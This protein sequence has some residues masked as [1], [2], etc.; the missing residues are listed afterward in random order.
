[1]YI[2]NLDQVDRET[3]GVGLKAANLGFLF[4]S[5][6][7]VPPGFVVTSEA[8]EKFLT[9]TGI[10]ME[11][12][13]I[14]GTVN[15][16]DPQTAFRA[17]GW[18]KEMF[19]KVSGMDFLI[20]EL[21]SAYNELS[22]GKDVSSAG[23]AALDIVRAGRSECFVS[24]RP[25]FSSGKEACFSGHGKTSL[26]LISHR[27]VLSGIKDC[28]LS[29]F[30]P[31]ALIY[32][33]LQGVEGFSLGVIV[34]KMADSELSGTLFTSEPI[35]G[36]RGKA[37]V[38]GFWGLG[39]T[40]SSGNVCPDQFLIDKETGVT[41]KKISRKL[42]LRR[43]GPLSGVTIQEKVPLSRV[44]AETLNER[45]FPKFSLIAK[46]AEE[47][48]EGPQ[49][50]E[51]GVD[52][53]KI[54]LLQARPLVFSKAQGFSNA[55]ATEQSDSLKE[56]TPPSF[57]GLGVSAGTAKGKA[58]AVPDFSALQK[59]ETPAILLAKNL[60][61]EI[62]PYLKWFSG[63]ISEQGGLGSCLASIARESGIPIVTGI[64]NATIIL[65][66]KEIALDGMAGSVHD[67]PHNQKTYQA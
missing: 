5:G 11:L 44:S 41:E 58:L 51:W 47:L 17:C 55:Q 33:K 50:I 65:N 26:N 4:K 23:G 52:R 28:W 3:P 40:L 13:G 25:S 29:V 9:D 36:D 16:E 46:K 35:S 43:R 45:D 37:L 8:F 21:R 20:R 12:P 6:F 64:E 49:E 31:E 54:V 27:Q 57:Q 19:A 7:S 24:I 22:F 1:M 56:A 2:L 48:L 39:E 38:E 18:I 15:P 66:G 34:Q 59:P 30:S 32:R 67:I 14:L 53:G 42:F 61:M 10:S 60:G 63:I 62:L